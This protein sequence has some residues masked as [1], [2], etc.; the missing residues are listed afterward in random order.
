MAPAREGLTP[1]LAELEFNDLT[2]PVYR[3]VDGA[4]VLSGAEVRDGLIR[5]V[6]APVMW[7]ETIRRMREDGIDTF[8]EVGTGSVLSGLVR[9][10]DREATCYQAGTVEG[11]E[12]TLQELTKST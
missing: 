10:I 4:P 12:N 3:N 8:V 2:M 9:R 1:T 5:Q 11:I 7:S 6:D